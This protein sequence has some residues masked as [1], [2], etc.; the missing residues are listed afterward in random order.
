M[1]G[2][3]CVWEGGGGLCAVDCRVCRRAA[4]GLPRAIRT[5][6]PMDTVVRVHY[7]EPVDG[8]LAALVT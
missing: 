2:T 7:I 4:D 5:Q 8:A 6:H 3:P 1:M